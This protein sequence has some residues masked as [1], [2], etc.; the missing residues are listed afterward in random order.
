LY[1]LEP[2]EILQF[3]VDNRGVTCLFSLHHTFP[4]EYGQLA[5]GEAEYHKVD[6]EVQQFTH[7][8]VVPYRH[9]DLQ[10]LRAGYYDPESFGQTYGLAW[11]VVRNLPNSEIVSFTLAP[12]G[13]ALSNDGEKVLTVLRSTAV[14]DLRNMTQG[15]AYAT[16]LVDKVLPTGCVMRTAD[17]FC[18]CL[19]G[20][21]TVIVAGQLVEDIAVEVMWQP[22]TAETWTACVQKARK[23][24]KN[25]NVPG[26]YAARSLMYG[27]LIGFVSLLPQEVAAGTAVLKPNRTAMAAS[28][29]L[30]Q[31]RFPRTCDFWCWFLGAMIAL[32]LAVLVAFVVH[33]R[34]LGAD[35]AVSYGPRVLYSVYGNAELN[36]IDDTAFVRMDPVV[37]RDRKNVQLIGV[38]VNQYWPVV[39][40]SS[41]ENELLAVT[42]RG[43][44]P[45]RAMNE[46]LESLSGVGVESLGRHF[47]GLVQTT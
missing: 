14:L 6:G 34:S 7:G 2:F 30:S 31:F 32:L 27:A 4:S 13:L 18:V 33:L 8:N 47:P 24:L 11:S 1:Y 44:A 16:S 10:W 39:A 20:Q 36:P 42:N 40:A 46:P 5:A 28:V 21:E 35:A 26:P 41:F 38:A 3:L 15:N 43:C 9:N 12:R 23:N 17:N 37:H 45:K 25:Y 19:T 29:A 22:R